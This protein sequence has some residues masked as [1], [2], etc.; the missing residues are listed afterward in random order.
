MSGAS[1]R[2]GGAEKAIIEAV[3]AGVRSYMVA[4]NNDFWSRNLPGDAEVL[5]WQDQKALL[6]HGHAVFGVS[7]V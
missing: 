4:G 3:D 7:M 2:C 1:R 6:A 5:L